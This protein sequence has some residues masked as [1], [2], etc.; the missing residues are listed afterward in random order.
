VGDPSFTG[1]GQDTVAGLYDFPAR[2]YSYQG[3]WS[4]PDPAG[5]AA[6]NPSNPQSWNRYAYVMNNPMN[7]VDPLGLSDCPDLKFTCGD[8]PGT[9][10]GA[11]GVDLWGGGGGLGGVI[12]T[13]GLGQGFQGGLCVGGVLVSIGFGGGGGS[14]VQNGGGSTPIPPPNN[15]GTT[16]PGN[17]AGQIICVNIPGQNPVCVSTSNPNW[18]WTLMNLFW[19]GVPWSATITY[20]PVSIPVSYI[21][22][23]NTV[24]VG[25]GLAAGVSLPDVPVTVN[26]GP[27]VYGDLNNARDGL[28]G[29]SISYGLQPT[30]GIGWQHT[31][32]N[33]GNLLGP[34]AGPWGGNIGVTYSG[35][36]DF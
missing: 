25:L 16:F 28:S 17:P 18:F 33:S 11:P 20:T 24:C 5:L 8:D 12:G 4:S 10:T 21:P 29:F 30:P 35:C 1:Q 13:C 7:S 26:G 36:K 19:A 23:T 6:V 31:F 22:K 2:E 34:T 3:R 9:S 15:P 32:N 27:L 14:R